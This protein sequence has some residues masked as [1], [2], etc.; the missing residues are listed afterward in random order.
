VTKPVLGLGVT[1]F[2]SLTEPSDGLC[3][4]SRN[5]STVPIHPAKLILGLGIVPFSGSLNIFHRHIHS[6]VIDKF[7]LLGDTRQARLAFIRL[8]DRMA[9]IPSARHALRVS[10]SLMR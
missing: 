10:L 2:S 1:L 6:H 8:A 3:T 9:V 7:E 5:A 4:V